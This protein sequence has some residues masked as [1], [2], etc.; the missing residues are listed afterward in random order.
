MQAP[1]SQG[2]IAYIRKSCRY[3]AENLLVLSH[4]PYLSK[5][6][7][8]SR[9]PERTT[10]RTSA[11]DKSLGDTGCRIGAEILISA[12]PWGCRILGGFKKR[13][14]DSSGARPSPPDCGGPLPAHLGQLG[15][16]PRQAQKHDPADP[17]HIPPPVQG[18]QQVVSR[19]LSAS[20]GWVREGSA[21]PD[22][23]PTPTPFA[24]PARTA[25]PPAPA[26]RRARSPCRPP[27][28]MPRLPAC[29]PRGSGCR[30]CRP[31]HAAAR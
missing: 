23:S 18:P 9:Y 30:T 16:N 25:P 2:K 17:F 15:L 21:L 29:R 8:A 10:H 14:A 12:P 20:G 26:R 3:P 11:P 7:T 19:G 5:A 28:S 27:A 31:R 1:G 13:G 24:D 4:S 6:G 22:G